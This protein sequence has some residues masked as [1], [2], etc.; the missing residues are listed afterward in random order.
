MSISGLCA[1]L[2]MF[3]QE[4]GGIDA[5]P[6]WLSPTG[7][8]PAVREEM[9]Q[10]CLRELPPQQGALSLGPAAPQLVQG[11]DIGDRVTQGALTAPV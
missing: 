3:Q 8:Q 6:A 5:W 4:G 2:G 10:S 9:L 7:R 1:L 11:A